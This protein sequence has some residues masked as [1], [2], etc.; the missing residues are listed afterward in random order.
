MN[1]EGDWRSQGLTSARERSQ[2]TEAR[3]KAQT[4]GP[5]KLG[6]KTSPRDGKQQRMLTDCGTGWGKLHKA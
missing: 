5:W 4:A 1:L 3:T 6:K 2:E